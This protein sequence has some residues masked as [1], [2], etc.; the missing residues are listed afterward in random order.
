VGGHDTAVVDLNRRAAA[1]MRAE[2]RLE[3][4][5][6]AGH[7]FE[8]PGALEAVSRMTVGWCRRYLGAA[9]T[10]VSGSR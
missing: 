5:P 1:A 2:L 10:T 7:L 8:E 6:G 4:V 3:V 9:G